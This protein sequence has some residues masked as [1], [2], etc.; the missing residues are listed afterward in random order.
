MCAP[1]VKDSL[2]LRAISEPAFQLLKA[3]LIRDII[4]NVGMAYPY[5]L[6]MRSEGLRVVDKIPVLFDP[7]FEFSQLIPFRNR[8]R[9]F[10]NLAFD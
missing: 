9:L 8:D 1:V 7:G 5:L 10:V 4:E 3:G 2:N 6:I